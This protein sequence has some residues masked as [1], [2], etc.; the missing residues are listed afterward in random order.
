MSFYGLNVFLAPKNIGIDTKI[1]NFELIVTDVRPFE[2]FGGQ[3]G[4]HLEKIPFRCSDFGKL[5][6]S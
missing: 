5:L 4:R 1:I 2:G 6:M 3:R